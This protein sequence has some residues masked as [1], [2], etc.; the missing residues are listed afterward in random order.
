MPTDS[1]NK[2]MLQYDGIGGLL[3]RA[4]AIER[5][6]DAAYF[7]KAIDID[8]LFHVHQVGVKTAG[9]IMISYVSALEA[10]GFDAATRR[11]SD[12]QSGLCFQTIC[13]SM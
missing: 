7:I 10:D 3:L 1:L 5:H 2:A 12:D 13:T 6:G 8:L 9:I 11:L 4:K